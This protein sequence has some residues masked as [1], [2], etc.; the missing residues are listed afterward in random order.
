MAGY[1]SILGKREIIPGTHM[2]EQTLLKQAQVFHVFI[3]GFLL[4]IIIKDGNG[5]FAKKKMAM[6]IRYP[7]TRGYLTR[8]VQIWIPVFTHGC[9]YG[10]DFISTDKMKMG[11]KK[12]CTYPLPET[13][14]SLQYIIT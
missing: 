6:H 8:G 4:S 5:W 13:Q 9:G 1:Y 7:C 14:D 2:D 10:F 11:T 3:S 12:S